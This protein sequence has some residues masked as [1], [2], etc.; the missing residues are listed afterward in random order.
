MLWGAPLTT[1]K[2]STSPGCAVTDGG[3]EAVISFCGVGVQPDLVNL[4]RLGARGHD[5]QRW[6]QRPPCI[7]AVLRIM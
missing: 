1:L 5:A 6:H 3:L 7:R 2:A 4:L